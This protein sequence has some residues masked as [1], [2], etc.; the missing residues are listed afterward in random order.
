[1]SD[2]KTN[3]LESGGPD[4]NYLFH[5]ALKFLEAGKIHII[6]PWS[7]FCKLPIACVPT[8]TR[9][10]ANQHAMLNWNQDV[11][12]FSNKEMIFYKLV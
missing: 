12:Q 8:L 7:M 4:D 6:C 5:F 10:I 9:F 1:M 11:T 3:N 2:C